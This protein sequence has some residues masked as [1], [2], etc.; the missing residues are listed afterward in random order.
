[1]T[2]LNK[3]ISSQ[4]AQHSK[5]SRFALVEICLQ[6]G[7]RLQLTTGEYDYSILDYTLQTLL[8]STLVL[9]SILTWQINKKLLLDRIDRVDHDQPVVFPYESHPQS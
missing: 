1:M 4:E 2:E 8:Y 3:K 7:R 6:G 5:A 9:Y